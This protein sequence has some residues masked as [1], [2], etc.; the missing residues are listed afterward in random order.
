A[1]SETISSEPLTYGP[2]EGWPW[3]RALLANKIARVNGYQIEP[4][5][6]AITQG[7]TGALLAAM[8][9]TVDSGDEVLIPDPCWPH[10]YMQLATSSAIPVPYPLDPCNEWQPDPE[11]LERLVTPRTRML[12]INTPGNPTGAVLPPTMIDHLLN[13]ARRHDLYLLADECY[14]EIV[15]EGQHVSPGTMLEAG[16]MET[17]RFIGVYTFSKTYAMTGWRVGYV[18]AGR[19]LLN[20]IVSVLCASHT[21]VSTIVQR[22][23]EAALSGSQDCAVEMRE[24]YRARRD[25]AVRL[26]KEH[27]R[28]TYTPHGAF[29]ALID[30][31]GPNGEPRHSRQFTLDLLR[32]RNVSVAA[33]SGFGHVS[34]SYVRI[35]LAASE[36]E[37][38]R[39]IREI[40]AFAG[41]AG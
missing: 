34:E 35:S 23:G 4:D 5:N 36:T 33:G 11:Q 14:D 7:G 20:T 29:Y 12:I 30:I 21:S 3:L 22:A 6:I 19:E 25:L 18:V 15:F 9:A 32:E 1:A 31:S 37:I 40:C 13:F 28:Y 39:G 38:E 41:R 27:G 16:E 17:G 10:Y 24:A 8:L 2:P 26:L